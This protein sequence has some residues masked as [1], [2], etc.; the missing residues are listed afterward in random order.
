[1]PG[2][3]WIPVESFIFKSDKSLNLLLYCDR[4]TGVMILSMYIKTQRP[5]LVIG[6]GGVR[7]WGGW[8][9][10]FNVQG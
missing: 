6:E 4:F 5:Y 8:V 3:Y 9:S 2:V 1:M 7:G 10:D